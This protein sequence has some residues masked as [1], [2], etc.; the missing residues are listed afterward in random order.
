MSEQTE[1][2][3]GWVPVEFDDDPVCWDP[4]DVVDGAYIVD[5]SKFAGVIP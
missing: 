4:E 3:D 1:S 5:R 2:V